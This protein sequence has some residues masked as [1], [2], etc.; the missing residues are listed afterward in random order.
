M[1]NC[2]TLALIFPTSDGR[3]VGIVR[4]RTKAS[5]FTV[6]GMCLG[7]SGGCEL[8]TACSGYPAFSYLFRHHMYMS[9]VE[10]AIWACSLLCGIYRLIY[11]M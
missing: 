8:L 6:G 7:E 5:E 11:G 10:L 4:W 2:G 3:F 1:L 9:P